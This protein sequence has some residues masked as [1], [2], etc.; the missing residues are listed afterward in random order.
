MSRARPGMTS[1]ESC[2]DDLLRRGYVLIE[3]A[4]A[5][6]SDAEFDRLVAGSD[7]GSRRIPPTDRLV[8][9]LLDLPTVR[10]LAA[11]AM[12]RLARPVRA[13]AFDKTRGSNWSVPW[14]QDRTIAVD[15][16]DEGPRSATGRS[17]RACHIASR[18]S[19]CSRPC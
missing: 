2:E 3:D 15:R 6:G 10:D 7:S 17:S 18:R 9:W 1:A 13:I 11:K 4:A 5:D 19:D 8:R 16:K 12:G 14:H